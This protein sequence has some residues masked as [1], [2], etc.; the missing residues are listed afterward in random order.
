MN[1]HKPL[2][3]FTLDVQFKDSAFFAKKQDDIVRIIHE[4]MREK[5]YIPVLD[6]N[7]YITV[8]Y[9]CQNDT[10]N[11]KVTCHGTYVGRKKS[12]ELQGWTMGRLLPINTRAAK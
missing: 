2:K 8:E 1:L 5:G 7:P 10:F 3:P 9:D 11:Y 6:L 4:M 12:W